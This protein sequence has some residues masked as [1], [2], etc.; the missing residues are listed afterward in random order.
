MRPSAERWEKKGKSRENSGLQEEVF[1]GLAPGIRRRNEPKVFFLAGHTV[2]FLHPLKS[3]RARADS[4]F[5]ISRAT[6][7]PSGE[8]IYSQ[9]GKRSVHHGL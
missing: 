9:G 8:R 4:L 6:R 7:Q 5:V 2:F 1:E 3:R